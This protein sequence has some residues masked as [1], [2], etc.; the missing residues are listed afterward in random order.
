MNK[1]PTRLHRALISGAHYGG[2]LGAA[3]LEGLLV[4]RLG[5]GEGF[6]PSKRCG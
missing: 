2:R 4:L 5:E 1:G 6:Q 3:F